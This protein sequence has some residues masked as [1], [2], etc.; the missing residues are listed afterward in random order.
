MNSSGIVQRQGEI[1]PYTEGKEQ[2][3]IKPNKSDS[4]VIYQKEMSKDLV[5]L[6][7]IRVLIY[8]SFKFNKFYSY[9]LIHSINIY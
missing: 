4:M 3:V 7:L 1:I 8:Y 2:L 6:L 5:T 9:Q